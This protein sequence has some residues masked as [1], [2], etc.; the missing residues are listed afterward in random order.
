ML[1][2]W[3]NKTHEHATSDRNSIGNVYILA[4]TTHNTLEIKVS[5]RAEA[6]SAVAM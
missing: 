1:L 5:M 2:G 4:L 6:G 3:C